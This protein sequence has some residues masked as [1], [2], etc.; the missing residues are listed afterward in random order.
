MFATFGDESVHLLQTEQ[1][2]TTRAEVMV[3]G[4]K[5]N[6]VRGEAS[7]GVQIGLEEV[8]S[9]VYRGEEPPATKL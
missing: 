9:P 7:S 2:Y 8:S 4:D 5:E 1:A 6:F 3:F